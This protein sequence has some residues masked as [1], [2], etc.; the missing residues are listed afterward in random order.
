MTGEHCSYKAVFLHT[1]K[2]RQLQSEILD[3]TYGIHRPDGSANH[4][5][6][7]WFDDCFDRLK[8]WL[9]T[10]PEPRGTVST[11]GYAISFHSERSNLI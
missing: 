4:P 9:S 10:A 1:T 8:T 11:E 7:G 2:L 6:Q 3:H 5:A